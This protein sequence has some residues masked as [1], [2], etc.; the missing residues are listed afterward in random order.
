MNCCLVHGAGLSLLC[1]C[2]LGA[3][4]EAPDAAKK[5]IPSHAQVQ[6]WIGELGH[7]S[8]EVRENATR[9]LIM[10]W[11]QSLPEV[12]KALQSPDAEV[13]DRASNIVRKIDTNAG[14]ILKQLGAEFSLNGEGLVRGVTFS[15]TSSADQKKAVQVRD[16]DLV[17]LLALPKLES[18][19]LD[20]TKIT[21]AALEILGKSKSLTHLVLDGTQI[22]DDGLAQLDGMK[23]LESLSICKTR[24]TGRGFVHFKQLK[25]LKELMLRDS[26]I[27]D[28]GL[29]KGVMGLQH[30][31]QLHY[32]DLCSTAITDTGMRAVSR[33]RQIAVLDCGNTRITDSG[34]GALTKLNQLAHLDLSRTCI[35]N[36]GLV[37]LK[38]LPKLEVICLNSTKV[39]DE[40]ISHLLDMKTL[41]II[42]LADCRTTVAGL[43]KLVLLPCLERL[44]YRQNRL[45]EAQAEELH[46]ALPRIGIVFR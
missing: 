17:C 42:G 9:L 19:A 16:A 28:D 26:P 20:G 22:S 32:L 7:D 4:R 29:A 36:A 18:V 25:R 10:S 39:N 15:R 41:T 23:T 30:L 27:D 38:V 6:K 8:F 33:L 35:T 24:I 46:K 44:D 40:A 34:L 2:T 5:P 14:A 45:S 31:S 43:K 3:G 12:L 21:D 37:H 13:R 1:L 11:Q